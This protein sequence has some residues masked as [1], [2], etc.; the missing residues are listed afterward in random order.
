MRPS[1]G[2][3]VR[4]PAAKASQ[5]RILPNQSTRFLVES[6]RA[7]ECTDAPAGRSCDWLIMLRRYLPLGLV[8]PMFGSFTMSGCKCVATSLSI[9]MPAS[10]RLNGS[11]RRCYP[12]RTSSGRTDMVVKVERFQPAGLDIRM[13]EGKAAYSHVVTVTGPGKLIYTAGQLARDRK[14]TRLNSSHL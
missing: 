4:S 2:L 6:A 8:S 9:A 1:A 5:R 13:Q 10:S 14:S 12:H 7:P 3:P 11:R